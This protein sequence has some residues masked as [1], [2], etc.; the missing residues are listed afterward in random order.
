MT[1]QTFLEKDSSF[2]ISDLILRLEAIKA[3]RGDLPVVIEGYDSDDGSWTYSPTQ[4]DVKNTSRKI[5]P[6]PEPDEGIWYVSL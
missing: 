3:E 6:P 1:A 4:P 5:L 2:K